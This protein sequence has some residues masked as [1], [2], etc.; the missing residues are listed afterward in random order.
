MYA[1]VRLPRPA[2]HSLWRIADGFDR[3]EEER[4]RSA[5]QSTATIEPRFYRIRPPGDGYKPAPTTLH[6]QLQ[7][8]PTEINRLLQH[9]ISA[10]GP[11][12]LDLLLDDG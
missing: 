6:H 3:E 12:E 1:D 11:V 2:R 10:I 7:E 9:H 5:E 4:S 8:S